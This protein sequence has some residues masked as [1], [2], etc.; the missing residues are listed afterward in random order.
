[1]SVDHTNE[2]ILEI[3]KRNS[4]EPFVNIAKETGL[5][6]STVRRRVRDMTG[7][8]VIKRFTVERGAEN[9]TQAIVLV[10]VESAT[11]TA[12]VSAKLIELRGV[13]VVYEITGQYDIAAVISATNITEINTAIDQVRKTDGV[14]DTNSVII[15]HTL[16]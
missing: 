15:L 1:V 4:R 2:R 14:T 9:Y 8:G 6:E 5:K 7:S 10:S 16:T 12:A 13:T 3:L 11:D